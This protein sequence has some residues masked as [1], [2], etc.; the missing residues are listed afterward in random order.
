M[1]VVDWDKNLGLWVA[2]KKEPD[3]A[4]VAPVGIFIKNTPSRIVYTPRSHDEPT[5]N[6]V[7][8]SNPFNGRCKRWDRCRRFFP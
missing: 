8:K 1:G 4:M 2:M 3:L 5:K 6:D 7:G